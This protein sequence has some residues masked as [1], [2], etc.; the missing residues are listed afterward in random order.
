MILVDERSIGKVQPK[1]M[2][3]FKHQSNLPWKFTKISLDSTNDSM[4]RPTCFYAT[5]V[6]FEGFRTSSRA[7]QLKEYVH[8]YVIWFRY[9][10][11]GKIILGQLGSVGLFDN[12][13]F[14]RFS[15]TCLSRSKART[16]FLI[17]QKFVRIRVVLIMFYRQFER[18]YNG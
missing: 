6:N 8:R 3:A 12:Q 15:P 7:L 9:S 18:N 16:I 5:F 13:T 17:Y 2:P 14:P 11:T 4:M 10:L 1:I